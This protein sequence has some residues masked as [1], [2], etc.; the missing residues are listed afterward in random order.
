MYGHCWPGNSAWI[1]FINPGGRAYWSSL[2][3][4]DSFKGTSDIFGIWLDMNEPSV[5]DGTE[6]TLAKDSIHHSG[7][8]TIIL[9]KDVHNA[10]GR[11]MIEATY[12]GLIKR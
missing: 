4:Y 10:Y 11:K 6:N 8:G 12:E 2:Y 9:H 7:D 3:K 1:D 5:F